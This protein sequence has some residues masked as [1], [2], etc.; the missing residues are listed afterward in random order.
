MNYTKK[1]GLEALNRSLLLMS[2]DNKKTLTENV[3]NIL[4]EQNQTDVKKL[5][6]DAIYSFGTDPDTLKKVFDQ[7]KTKQDYIKLDNEIKKN[8]NNFSVGGTYKSILDIL[9][10][11]LERDNLDIAKYITGKLKGLG[12][13]MTYKVYQNNPKSLYPNSI[14]I[15]LEGTQ[16]KP[17]NKKNQAKPLDPNQGPKV[18]EFTCKVPNDKNYAY[19]S[20]DNNWFALNLK[21]NKRF[22]LT[23]LTKQF[24]AYK[25]T[26]DVLVK[27]CPTQL[28][29]SATTQTTDQSQTQQRN[30]EPVTQMSPLLVK[31]VESLV[32][33]PN[34]TLTKVE[35]LAPNN[36]PLVKEFCKQ[37][38]DFID[39]QDQAAGKATAT[40]QQRDDLSQCLQQ[41]NFGIGQGASRVKQRYGLTSSGGDKGIR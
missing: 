25:K 5:L 17:E 8:P 36:V 11:E 41:Y 13:N 12:I 37:L 26:I 16:S 2:Y 21:N 23:L 32:Q 31:Q 24:P 19:T 1:M 29:T 10:G 22:N 33:N 28:Q 15:N 6:R 4:I 20:K 30:N 3:D 27:T 39:E 34:I 35:E 7:L 9:N 18:T 14:R 38:F 40:P